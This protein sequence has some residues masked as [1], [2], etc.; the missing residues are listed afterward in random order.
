MLITGADEDSYATANE[1][2]CQFMTEVALDVPASASEFL[3]RAVAFCNAHLHGTLGSCILIDEDTRKAHREA[4]DKAVTDLEY[5]A[6]AVN[7]SPPLIFLSPWL[8]WGGNEEGKTFVSGQGN[9]GNAMNFDNVE[10]S[11]IT[12]GFMS[13]GHLI[14]SNKATFDTLAVDMAN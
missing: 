5:G 13:P 14:K 2:F 8:T 4:L 12:A 6:V 1:A 9:F 11:I 3:E 7:P 10:K